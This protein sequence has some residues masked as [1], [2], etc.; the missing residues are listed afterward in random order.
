M[1]LEIQ[2][3]VFWD[4]EKIFNLQTPEAQIAV[5]EVQSTPAIRR[6][7]ETCL[8]G[9]RRATLKQYQLTTTLTLTV[10]P[11]YN[12]SPNSNEFMGVDDFIFTVNKIDNGK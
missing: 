3:G 4:T 7:Y 6:E 9:K 10:Q 5:T 12:T 1:L 2:P 11:V 8:Q